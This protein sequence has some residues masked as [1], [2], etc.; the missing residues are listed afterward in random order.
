M[1]KESMVSTIEVL[2]A[3]AGI[4]DAVSRATAAAMLVFSLLYTPCVAAVASIKREL[5]T[6]WA[7]CVVIW[8]CGIA[9]VAALLVRL[10][11]G[12]IGM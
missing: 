12:V 1:A 5:S 8:Q 2:F 11:C 7:V 10:I 6:K 3:P 9:W 4:A